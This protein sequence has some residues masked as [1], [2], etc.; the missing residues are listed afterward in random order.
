MDAGAGSLARRKQTWDAGLPVQIGAHATHNV[1]GGRVYRRGLRGEI[2]AKSQA[3]FVDRRE[4][5]AD[6]AGIL[7]A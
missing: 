3:G 2:N 4:T 6:P 7:V 5:L 1:V